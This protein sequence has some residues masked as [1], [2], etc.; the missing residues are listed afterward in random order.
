MEK[1]KV[2]KVVLSEIPFLSHLKCLPLI[3]G[4]DSIRNETKYPRKPY[5]RKKLSAGETICIFFSVSRI[6]R[7]V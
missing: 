1:G 2:F 5:F 3:N 6:G 7:N 4:G